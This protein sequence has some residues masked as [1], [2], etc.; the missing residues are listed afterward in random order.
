MHLLIEQVLVLTRYIFRRNEV[1]KY[2]LVVAL[3]E[4]YSVGVS[5]FY[6]KSSCYFLVC[7]I[8]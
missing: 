3:V 1:R 5:L 7:L 4:H 6:F 2:D 8:R